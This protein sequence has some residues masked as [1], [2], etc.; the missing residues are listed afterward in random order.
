MAYILELSVHDIVDVLRRKGHLDNRIF[1][2]SSMQEGTRLHSLY[3]S[4]QGADYLSEYS[5]HKTYQHGKYLFKV[6]GK[7]DGVYLGKDGSVTIEEIKTTVADLDAFSHDHAEW[8]LSQ[9]MFYADILAKDRHVDNV[10]IVLTYI[11]QNDYKKRKKIEKQ[12]TK[13]ELDSYVDGLI[14]EYANYMDKILEMKEERNRTSKDLPFPYPSLRKG[15]KRMM[16]YV[17]D[18]ALSG[19]TV[20]I[21]A[22]TGIGKTL[23][24]LFPLLRLFGEKKCDHVF[25]LT[26]KNAIKTIAMNALKSLVEG[27]AKIKSLLITSKESIC[28]NDKK[29]HCN[30]DECPFAR[31]YYDKLLDSTFDILGRYDSIDRERIVSFCLEKH[32]CPFQFQL[33]LSRYVDILIADYTYVYDYHDRLDLE[34]SNI[35][36]SDSYLLVDECHNLP[37][38][39]RDMYSLEVPQERI[40]QGIS[41]CTGKELSSMR[42]DLNK[43]SKSFEAI[44]IDEER[45]QGDVLILNSLPQDFKNA[46]SS[47]LEHFKSMMKK[48]PHFLNDD[49]YEVFYLLNSFDYLLSLVSQEGEE[50][51]LLYSHLEEEKAISAKITCLDPTPFIKQGNRLFKAAFFFTATLS[52]KDY[53]IDLLGG[54]ILDRSSRLVMDSPFPKENRL[55]LVDTAPSLL[56]RDRLESLETIRRTVLAA[57]AAKKGN[58]FVFCPSFEYLYNLKEVLENEDLDLF[59]QTRRMQEDEREAFLNF[60]QEDD[61]RTRVA[62]LV[63]GGIFSEGIDLVG[64]RLIGAIVISIGLPQI[65]FERDRI[66]LYYETEEDKGKGFRYAYVY[67]GLNRILQAAGRVIRSEED[68]GIILFIDRRYNQPVFQ[69]VFDEIYPDAKKAYSPSSVYAQCKKF[70]EDNE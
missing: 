29:G 6:S 37:E 62:L 10:T 41:F 64:K 69:D 51:F 8:H 38:R 34:N 9:A 2:L 58:Y 35:A 24:C 7:A 16:E 44:E 32:L 57:I 30:P 5:V 26:S 67:P 42:K 28:F 45:R 46:V 60:F 59:V 31:N 43:L 52:P 3:Q 36:R 22:P 63:I 53:Y 47:F 13:K 21:E 48:A 19:K 65:A 50:G 17:H 12:F 18:N 33:D 4:E 1:N 54:D 66:R 27:K 20:F 55:V 25:Y 14:F 68:K 15:Q 56:Y 49:L 23:S 40:K 70:W 61:S 39:V 11:K